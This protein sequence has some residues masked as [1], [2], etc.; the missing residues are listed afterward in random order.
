MQGDP[1]R[2]IPIQAGPGRGR[3]QSALSKLKSTEDFTNKDKLS[4]DGRALILFLVVTLADESGRLT[5]TFRALLDAHADDD[6]HWSHGKDL[7]GI[8]SHCSKYLGRAAARIPSWNKVHDLITAAT[9]EAR[10]PTVLGYAAG[11]FCRAARVARPCGEYRGEILLPEWAGAEVVTVPAI[12]AC[13]INPEPVPRDDGDAERLR[14]ELQE[15]RDLLWSVVRGFRQVSAQ[16]NERDA[17]QRQ[18]QAAVRESVDLRAQNQRLRHRN[19]VLMKENLRLL[20]ALHPGTSTETLR[21][22]MLESHARQAER[23]GIPT[24]EWLGTRSG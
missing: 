8:Q 24:M 4:A 2:G 16:S 1:T 10:L 5:G 7:A 11:L 20:K 14:E 17:A 23:P 13:L 22:L 18:R 9:P 6:G 19:S 3:G 21:K 12:Q 15:T